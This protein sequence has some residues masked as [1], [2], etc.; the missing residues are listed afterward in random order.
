MEQISNLLFWISNGLLIP[1]IIGLLY[2][3]VKSIILLG[4]IV[5]QSIQRQK[6]EAQ[7]REWI[8]RIT[9]ENIEDVANLENIPESLF[10]MTVQQVMTG[11]NEAFID[12]S[13]CQ[14]ELERNREND[15]AKLLIKFGPILGLMGTLIPMGPAL[16]GLSTG[17]ISSMA[18]NM[19]V[20]F[21]TTV[22]GLFIGA[23]GFVLLQIK[24][25]WLQTDLM[26][27]DF[28]AETKEMA[29]IEKRKFN[30]NL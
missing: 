14:Y 24:Q 22:L 20:A 3:F 7:I 18:Y 27:L 16:A 19:Q 28:L 23:I 1:V 25:R 6:Q 9:M 12:K 29:T 15:S 30:S 8:D 5:G 10:L 13:I 17:D 4:K 2:F 21:A 11:S 26:R